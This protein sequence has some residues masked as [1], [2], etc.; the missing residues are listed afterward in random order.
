MHQAGL[1][2]VSGTEL[3]DLYIRFTADNIATI[4]SK[5]QLLFHA[6]GQESYDY[7]LTTW[8]IQKKIFETNEVLVTLLKATKPYP[9]L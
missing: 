4:K 1:D 9:N 8:G 5:E 6:I 3:N 7:S 2:L